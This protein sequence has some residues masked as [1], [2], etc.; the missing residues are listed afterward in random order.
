MASFVKVLHATFLCK[1][2]PDI[3][4]RPIHEGKFAMTLPLVVLATLCVLFGVFAFQLPLGRLI[5]PAVAV[6]IQGVWWAGS[7]TILII[8]AIAVGLGIY[9]LTMRGGKLRRVGTYVGGEKLEDVY[10]SG[11]APGPARHIEVTGVDFYATIEQLPLLRRAYSMARARAFDVYRIGQRSAG[12]FVGVLR[13]AHSGV[14]PAYLRWF[15][16][17]ML[18]VVWVVSQRG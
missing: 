7:A 11:E 2:S 5:L 10:V 14:L 6:E 16:V 9:W 15:V 1:P 12:Y 4:S 8:G 3:Q 17:G 18:V 13:A